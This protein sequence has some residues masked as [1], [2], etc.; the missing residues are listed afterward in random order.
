MGKLTILTDIVG[1]DMY[2]GEAYLGTA[3]SSAKWR[4]YKVVTYNTEPLTYYA[5]HDDRFTKS[6][7]LRITGGYAYG[8]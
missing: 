8:P 3:T 4:I 6:W 2:V 7:D 1:T 5:D